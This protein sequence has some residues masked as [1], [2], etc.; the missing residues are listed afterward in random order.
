MSSE[1]EDVATDAVEAETVSD[2]TEGAESAVNAF[3][4]DD[5]DDGGNEEVAAGDD[6]GSRVTSSGGQERTADD[7]EAVFDIPVSVTAV[8]GRKRMEVS[9]L[10]ELDAGDVIELD[11]TVGEAIDIYINDRLVA[12]GE[13]VLVEEK[14]GVTMTE[15]IKNS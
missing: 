11:R 13:V 9:K 15:I 5:F 2:I 1:D 3:A 7:L 14:L 10:L 12:R 4:P 6:G 8:L